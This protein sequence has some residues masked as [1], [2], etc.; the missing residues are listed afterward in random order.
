[1]NYDIRNEIEEEYFESLSGTRDKVI[2]D[3]IKVKVLISSSEICRLI[4]SICQGFLNKLAVCTFSVIFQ[5]ICSVYL[6]FDRLTT[7]SRMCI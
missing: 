3:I 1:M 6:P 7:F 2:L 5:V 4:L